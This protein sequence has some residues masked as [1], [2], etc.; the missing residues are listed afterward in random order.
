MDE[1]KRDDL[2]NRIKNAMGVDYSSVLDKKLDTAKQFIRITKEGKVDVIVKDAFTGEQKICLY[3]IGKLYAREAALATTDEVDNKELMAQLGVRKGSLLPWLK[4]LRD[5]G[6]I[7][8]TQKGKNAYHSIPI[9]EIEKV[10]KAVDKKL[11]KRS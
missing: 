9:S 4:S 8:D 1:N 7:R 11:N 3:L 6:I 5:S 10:L 2:K